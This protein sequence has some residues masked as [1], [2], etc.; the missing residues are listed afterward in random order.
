[1]KLASTTVSYAGEF[2]LLEWIPS[3]KLNPNL[4]QPVVY[5]AH[6]NTHAHTPH[7]QNQDNPKS[8]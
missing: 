3:Y 6:R 2:L 5:T 8:L 4:A 1:M 7:S